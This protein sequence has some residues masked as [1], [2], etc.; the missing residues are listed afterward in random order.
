MEL[1]PVF[2][3][4]L[5]LLHSTSKESG[6]QL[7]AMLDESI[8]MKKN[9]GSAPSKMTVPATQQGRELHLKDNTDRRNLDKLKRD[10]SELVPDSKKPRLHSPARSSPG[11]TASGG[12]SKS[13][14]PSPTPTP[15]PPNL[16][17]HPSGGNSSAGELDLDVDLEGL[18]D[19][20]CQICKTLNQGNGNKLVECHTCQNLYHQ[21]C[22]QPVISNQEAGDPR[23][24]WNCSNCSGPPI[25]KVTHP[26]TKLASS[27]PPK[28]SSSLQGLKS[29]RPTA[30]RNDISSS[31]VFK[32][33]DTSK[34]HGGTSASVSGGKP[35]G[36]AA[37]A[38][39]YKGSS[40][41]GGSSGLKSSRSGSLASN[42]GH[43]K[44]STGGSSSSS[45]SNT[46]VSADKRLQL[47][48]KKA[49]QRKK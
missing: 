27:K 37:L 28:I 5:R 31:G 24:V 34:S 29:T 35:A 30:G 16:V 48:K 41:S 17:D 18:N 32:R 2:V 19:L 13:H 12:F 15:T 39:T 45:T 14:T 11:I 26:S 4:A 44:S 8:R 33:T 6:M 46:M 7:K 38:A 25:P 47:M 36:M 10:L 43:S 9:P 40:G 42:F 22:H 1:D 23:L 49:A 21:E 20:I 3:R